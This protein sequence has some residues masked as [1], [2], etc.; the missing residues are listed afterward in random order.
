MAQCSV[1]G[2]YKYIRCSACEGSGRLLLWQ[3]TGFV[4]SK[5]I[6]C[7]ETGETE[8]LSCSST[9]ALERT[10]KVGDDIFS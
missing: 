6:H 5:C 10:G 2:D 7:N 8:C 1:C 9:K 3:S 4:T